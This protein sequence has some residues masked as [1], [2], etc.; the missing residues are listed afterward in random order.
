VGKNILEIS[1]QR[2]FCFEKKKNNL[3]IQNRKKIV[4]IDLKKKKHG[5]DAIQLW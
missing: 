4:L 2:F 5:I 1:I 3:L